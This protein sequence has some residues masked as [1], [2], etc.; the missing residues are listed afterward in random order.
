MSSRHS[1][2]AGRQRA[3]PK[4]PAQAES[5]LPP[6][7]LALPS[8]PASGH[9]TEHSRPRWCHCQPRPSLPPSLRRNGAGAGRGG[10]AA[11]GEVAAENTGNKKQKNP[12]R[13]CGGRSRPSV[14]ARPIPHAVLGAGEKSVRGS[15]CRRQPDTLEGRAVA[16]EGGLSSRTF[17]QDR[18]VLDLPR[19]G[20]SP[21]PAPG[22]PRAPVKGPGWVRTAL[23]TYLHAI[24]I[25]VNLGSRVW[26]ARPVQEAS[27]KEPR[28]Q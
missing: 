5:C 12:G 26:P 9:K 15:G 17:R 1:R 25:H 16:A 8:E 14:D 27:T 2:L 21:R 23:T 10:T 13:A 28:W 18:N 22:G 7:R 20:G 19:P 11:K 3:I 6:A 24:S 4:I